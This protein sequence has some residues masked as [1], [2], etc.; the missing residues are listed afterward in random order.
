MV[1]WCNYAPA[2]ADAPA[3]TVILT[4]PKGNGNLEVGIN[5]PAPEVEPLG[6]QAL[7]V[8]DDGTFYLLDNLNQRIIGL[9]P[10]TDS[11]WVQTSNMPLSPTASLADMVWQNN[12]FYLMSADGVLKL[13]A[14]VVKT[15]EVFDPIRSEWT[16]LNEHQAELRV[17]GEGQMSQTL[18]LTTPHYLG[19]MLLKQVD[20]QGNFYVL[21]EELLENV[22]AFIVETTVRRFLPTGEL[23]GI[24]RI[25]LN[26]T[27]FL[28]KRYIAITSHGN[29]YFLRVTATSAQVVELPFENPA[30]FAS[31]LTSIEKTSEVLKTSEVFATATKPITRPRIIENAQKYLQANWVLGQANYGAGNL[32]CDAHKWALPSYLKERLGETIPNVPYKWG[33]YMS[34]DSFLKGISAGKLAGDSCWCNGGDY[35]ITPNS[36]GVDCAGFVSQVWELGNYHT[37]PYLPNDSTEIKWNE[38]KPGDIL[39]WASGHVMLFDS[40]IDGATINGGIMVYESTSDP[41][42]NWSV[43][44][45]QRSFSQLSRYVPRRYQNVL[46]QA[47]APKILPKL[48]LTGTVHLQGRADSRGT[49]VLLSPEPC[50]SDPVGF[51]N[52]QSL[53]TATTD[54]QG[55]FTFT[56]TATPTYLCLSAVHEEYLS[57]MKSLTT[58]PS[59]VGQV[60][61]LSGDVKPDNQIDLFDLAFVALHYDTADSSADLNGDGLVNIFDLTIVAENYRQRGPLVWP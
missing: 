61:L 4:L 8:T 57:A 36:V 13:N 46:E 23:T 54:A 28:P 16:R 33:G 38:L 18:R 59:N 49:N 44:Y 58:T 29:L 5:D 52:P 19:T 31:K 14:E 30:D 41:I 37:T 53:I 3:E 26:E 45:N 32:S 21:V 15:S 9:S 7:A 51:Q 17:W 22:P 34:V 48:V 43:C 47:D 55:H 27:Y 10:S 24:A 50:P 2:L 20:A 35:C 6:P 42:C 40:F 60:T 39:N 1:V 12:N 56:V 25:P 11:V